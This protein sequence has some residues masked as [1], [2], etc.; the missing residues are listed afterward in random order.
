MVLAAGLLAAAIGLPAAVAAPP[1]PPAQ[2]CGTPDRAAKV[3]TLRT[4]DGVRLDAAEVG[5]GAR[6][7][8]LVHESGGKALCGWWPFAV[9]LADEGFHVLLFDLRCYGFSGCPRGSKASD[10]VSDVAAATARLRALGA[11]SVEVVGASMG[12]SI[13]LVSGV[14]V[15]TLAAVAD[16]SGDE[17]STPFGRKGHRLTA[18]QAA[19]RIRLPVLFA[20]ARGDPYVRVS[21]VRS[22]Y[23]HVRARGKALTVLPVT[24]GHGWD[25]LQRPDGSWSAFAGTLIRFLQAHVRLPSLDGCVRAGADIRIVRFAVSR[26]DSLRAAVLGDGTAGIVLS[27]QSD[28][29]LCSWLPFARTLT[30]AGYRVLVYDYGRARADAEAAAAAVELRRLGAR[31]VS[32]VGASEGAKASII[33]AARPATPIAGVVSL[34]AERY[35][36]GTDVLPSARKLS[37]P[38]LFV[39]ARGDPY[40]QSDTP[41]LYA[42]CPAAQKRLLLVPGDAHGVDLLVGPTADQVRA[43]ILSF[44]AARA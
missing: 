26:N 19:R 25:L 40:S 29:N 18:N 16:L 37:R 2:R 23:R 36:G 17:L 5:A 15:A 30:A 21:A 31:S 22:L 3:L 34:S 43:A 41:E 35:L 4:A 10:Y 42:A 24:E 20:V 32:L 13:A 39:T 7:V 27:N 8:V 11:A 44:L 33:A 6:G 38:A 12:G 1:A 9:R 28:R 14:R